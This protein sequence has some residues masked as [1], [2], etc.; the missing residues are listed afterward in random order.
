MLLPVLLF[1]QQSSKRT[2]WVNLKK[3]EVIS[4]TSS[5]DPASFQIVSP[6][7]LNATA[8]FDPTGNK[9]SFITDSAG[10]DSVLVSYRVFPF[11]LSKRV[12]NRDLS[13]YDSSK[14]F[15]DKIRRGKRYY[16]RRE[17]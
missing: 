1:A 13:V 11:N 9:V 6:D 4:D 10:P 3:G 16:E 8:V 14:Y 17:E 12:F 2:R 5:I 15:V 7:S